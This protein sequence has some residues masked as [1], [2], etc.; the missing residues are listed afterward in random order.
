MSQVRRLEII[1]P[2]RSQ[3]RFLLGDV[4]AISY[5]AESN[6]LGIPGGVAFGD[7]T[8]V[9]LPL[10]PTRLAALSRSDR[11]EAVPAAAVRQV[12]AFQVAKAREYVFM[13]P[14]AKQRAFVASQR[15]PTGP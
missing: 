11:F 3:S 6:A 1:Q 5:D 14:E 7:A 8:T 15:A 9:F 10:S 12:N 2:R 13:H 4:P